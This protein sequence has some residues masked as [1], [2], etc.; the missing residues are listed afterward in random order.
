MD[1]P[2]RALEKSME[3]VRLV[4]CNRTTS[5]RES[6]RCLRRIPPAEFIEQLW[7]IQLGFLEF[8][9]VIVSKDE[10]FFTQEDAFISLRKKNFA[11][12]ANLM[13]G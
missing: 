2:K 9:L 13:I 10:N 11:Q 5:I 12:D 7:N 8:P 3:M 4:G 1:S 6:I